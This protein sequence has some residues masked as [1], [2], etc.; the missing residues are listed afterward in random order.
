[1]AGQRLLATAPGCGAAGI[2]GIRAGLQPDDRVACTDEL[3]C[4]LLVGRVDAWLALD[5]YVRERFI[6]RR[7]QERVGVYAGAPA[8][9]RLADL[10]APDGAGRKP[11]R[12]LVVDVFKDYPVGNSSA[13]LPRALAAEGLDAE[14][15][16]LTAQARVVRIMQTENTPTA[17]TV[18]VR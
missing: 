18:R 3:A 12:V 5:D 16:L 6:V 13:W 4:L 2:E 1:V 14:P 10:F 17:R 15:L 7:G 9:V 11:A 8:A